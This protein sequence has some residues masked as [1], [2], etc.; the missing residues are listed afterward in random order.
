MRPD[1]FAE[2]QIAFAKAEI[3]SNIEFGEGL[4]DGV[5]GTNYTYSKTLRTDAML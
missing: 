1:S 2:Q 5:Q 4:F 3:E